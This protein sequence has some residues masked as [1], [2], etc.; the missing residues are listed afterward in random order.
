MEYVILVGLIAVAIA[1]ICVIV[2]YWSANWAVILAVL[3]GFLAI[4]VGGLAFAGA[5][6]LLEGD[7]SDFKAKGR[8]DDVLDDGEDLVLRRVGHLDVELVELARRAVG[9]RGLVAEA[10]RD[11]EV[12]VEARKS[13]GT[14]PMKPLK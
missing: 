6:A 5:R 8:P 1:L 12:A 9:A 2:A 10:R 3:A 14:H 4:G 7:T 13:V 11:L